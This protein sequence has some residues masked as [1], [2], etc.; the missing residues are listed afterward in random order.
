MARRALHR[1]DDELSLPPHLTSDLSRPFQFAE[2]WFLAHV[3][4]SS[5]CAIIDGSQRD[6]CGHVLHVAARR[7]PGGYGLG[8]NDV[9]PSVGDA[10]HYGMKAMQRIAGS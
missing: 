4:D 6:G 10:L 5:R 8:K 2:R 3:I 7:A 9:A 1:E